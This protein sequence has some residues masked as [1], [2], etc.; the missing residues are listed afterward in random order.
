M[1]VIK[2]LISKG[3]N[4]QA[5]GT[6]S[7]REGWTALMS[8]AANGRTECLLVLIDNGA[9]V[10]A[11]KESG[12]TAL[13]LAAK[14]GQSSCVHELVL[15]GADVD[16]MDNRGNTAMSLAH[17]CGHTGVVQQLVDLGAAFIF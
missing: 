11:R 17:I 15:H 14:Y 16:L 6:D 13:M 10:N 8:A 3:A 5:S 9:N 4:V 1:D 7:W 2:L 12:K